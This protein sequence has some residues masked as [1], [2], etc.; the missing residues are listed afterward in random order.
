MLEI[1]LVVAA[2]SILVGLTF[3]ALNPARFFRNY[4]DHQREIH[5]HDLQVAFAQLLAEEEG[6]FPE[7]I[8][9][10]PKEICDT[11]KTLG[12]ASPQP[13]CGEL[14]NLSMLVPI[15]VPQIPKDPQGSVTASF[16]STA[17]AQSLSGTGYFIS[18]GEGGRLFIQ[19]PRSETRPIGLGKLYNPYSLEFDGSNDR[20]E[21]GGGDDF[22]FDLNQ[23]FTMSAWIYPDKV[24]DGS[25][26]NRSGIFDKS[27]V[28][29]GY[30][31]V[32]MPTSHSGGDGEP[33]SV[34]L[35]RIQFGIREEHAGTRYTINTTV[36]PRQWHHVVGV[37]DSINSQI[38]LYINGEVEATGGA[39]LEKLEHANVPLGLGGE[40]G[41]DGANGWFNG[42]INNSRIYNRAL[43]EQEIQNL[44][45]GIH[46]PQGLV[47]WW[48][49][50][51]GEGITTED[52]SGN[53][54]HGTLEG[55]VTWSEDTL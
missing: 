27:T 29:A 15:Y 28:S 20:V 8:T 54:N 31:I 14:V 46:I 13:D 2:V 44:Y 55:E 17:Y 51:E 32:G 11:G 43:S 22:A 38:Y 25:Y 36:I 45:N 26:N 34:D 39:N 3:A 37:Y 35:D 42:K 5:L 24:S 16:A 9:T 47:G 23:S 53:E 48:N 10:V 7:G 19:A 50:N 12:S 41:I 21:M 6:I 1:L 4:R 40:G 33:P 18:K 30:G 52:L 49:F